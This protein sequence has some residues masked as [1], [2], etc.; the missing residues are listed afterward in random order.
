V[1]HEQLF[2]YVACSRTDGMSPGLEKAFYGKLFLCP[3][4]AAKFAQA[5]GEILGMVGHIKVFEA[6]AYWPKDKTN[7][8]YR[9]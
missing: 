1:T 8:T 3:K 4:E 5:Q 7:F 9:F 6:I 2:Y